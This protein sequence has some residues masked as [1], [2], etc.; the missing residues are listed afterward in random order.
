MKRL[1]ILTVV[2]LFATVFFVSCKNSGGGSDLPIPKDAAMVFYLNT[3]SLTSKLSW[4]EIKQSS[5][6]QESYK[7][8]SDSFSKK[9]MDN[10]E[11]SGVD[12]K[13]DFAFFLRQRGNG[14]YMVVEGKIKDAGDFE[15]FALKSNEGS[16]VE[17]DGDLNYI[18]DDDNLISWNNSSFVLM[19]NMPMSG[20]ANNPFSGGME[21]E[22]DMNDMGE[23]NE[24]KAGVTPDSLKKFTK[25]LL[26]MKGDDLLNND[27]RFEDL[28]EEDGDMHFWMNPDSYINAM[29]AGMM[30]M[31]KFGDLLKGNISTFSLNF[32]DGKI[33]ISS[34]QFYGKELAKLMESYK[35]K[36]VDKDLINR[37]PSQNVIGAIA[38]NFDPAWLKGFLKA[39]G[40]D[41]LANGYLGKMDLSLDEVI[42]A[43][44]GQFLFSFSDLSLVK[45]EVTTPPFFEGG[46]P[47]TSVKTEPE[48]NVLVVSSV[49]NKSSF[50]KLMN[51]AKQNMM[52]MDT[53]ISY[54]LTNEWFAAGNKAESVDK[55]LAG[56]NNNVPF[57]DKISGHPFGMYIDL[58]KIFKATNSVDSTSFNLANQ[59]WQDIVATGGE[60]KDGMMKADFVINMVDKKT[61]SLK[62]LNQF[63]QKM[64]EAEKAKRGSMQDEVNNNPYATDTTAAPI[65]IAPVQ[66]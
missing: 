63:V 55:F 17:K 48:F 47:Y 39:L 53:A 30:S 23:T 4:D 34:K 1:P 66:Q 41:G 57:A 45:K 33:D 26:G 65:E 3:S 43:T 37:I 20:A 28:L 18:V 40:I 52:G 5:W 35:P 14:G 25:E 15:A 27:D 13:S 29:G 7:K 51:I 60:Y 50:D 31:F 10:P 36:N 24:T 54:K 38:F 46:E 58:Q 64:H 42:G 44:G 62:Q 32:A 56:G 12:M 19:S 59:T 8:E 2:A 61:N 49:G 6:F 21:G 16:K 9:I 22:E 11:A